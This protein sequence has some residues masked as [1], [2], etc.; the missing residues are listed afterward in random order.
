MIL[1]PRNLKHME[2]LLRQ[3]P[4][5]KRKVIVFVGRHPNE[6]TINIALHHHEKWEKHG[7]VVVRIPARWTPHWLWKT[8]EKRKLS[9]EVVKRLHANVPDDSQVTDFLKSKGFTA[10]VVHFHGTPV[11]NYDLSRP[12]LL[13]FERYG[14]AVAVELYFLDPLKY[15][16]KET[17]VGKYGRGMEEPNTQVGNNLELGWP[18]G[19]LHP[20][21]IDKI[22][23]VNRA[24][25]KAFSEK[26]AGK[27][28][29]IL[30]ELASK[31]LQRR[32]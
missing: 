27:F 32:S 25:I 8:A 26:H 10:P 23:Q 13:Q 18:R 4:E 15:R 11:D 20:D 28:E 19:Q 2:E 14:N 3:V 17:A 24:A 30:A 21:Y 31:G 7:A 1:R 9:K 22:G 16:R 5:A 6:G 12:S 29:E